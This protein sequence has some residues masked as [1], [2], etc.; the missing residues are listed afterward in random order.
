MI[1]AR[2][3]GPRPIHHRDLTV[4]NLAAA[5]RFCLTP[6]AAIA[7]ADIAEKMGV[8]DGVRAAVD[9]FHKHLPISRLQCD[10]LPDQPAVWSA[11]LGRSTVRLSKAAAEVVLSESVVKAKAL[12]M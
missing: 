1:A 10:I 4:D 8:E 6:E 3:A 5:I 7:A 11:K 2:G 9:S 12:R